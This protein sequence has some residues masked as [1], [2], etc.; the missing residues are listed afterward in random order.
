MASNTERVKTDLSRA[1]ESV[2]ARALA[3]ARAS[4]LRARRVA[5]R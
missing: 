4:C 5:S 2:R 3:L 1:A